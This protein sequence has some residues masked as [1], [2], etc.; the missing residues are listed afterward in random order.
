MDITSF[1]TMGTPSYCKGNDN[2]HLEITTSYLNYT[3]EALVV[4][5]RNGLVIDVPCTHCFGK[6]EFVICVTITISEEI[7]DKFID[8]LNDGGEL[9]SNEL[10]VISEQFKRIGGKYQINIE[11]PIDYKEHIEGTSML[12]ITDA[13]IVIAKKKYESFVGDSY[14]EL[15]KNKIWFKAMPKLSVG[16]GE[17]LEA[18]NTLIRGYEYFK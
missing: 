7:K 14:S 10:K 1:T 15:E 12:C 11:Y 6:K 2:P 18:M 4:A 3:G 9:S 17:L 16:I 13:D 5:L 8:G